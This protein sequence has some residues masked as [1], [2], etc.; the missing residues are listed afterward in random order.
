MYFRLP[1]WNTPA[2]WL[3]L[4]YV[5]FCLATHFALPQCIGDNDGD[6][7]GTEGYDNS[8]LAWTTSFFVGTVFAVLALSL[9]SR[10]SCCS[11][12]KSRRVIS[13][14]VTSGF[15]FG[16]FSLAFLTKGIIGR[17]FP[18]SGADDGH[19]QVGYFLLTFTSY[20]FW[21]ISSVFLLSLVRVAR[22]T[23]LFQEYYLGR[24]E[25]VIFFGLMI[26][27]FVLISLAC[28]WNALALWNVADFSVDDNNQDATATINNLPILLLTATTVAWN[29]LF[30]A[31]VISSVYVWTVLARQDNRNIMVEKVSHSVAAFVIVFLQLVNIVVVLLLTLY[32]VGDFKKVLDDKTAN[33][34]ASVVFNFCTLLTGWLLYNYILALF[35]AVSRNEEKLVDT[36][37]D[38]DGDE[39]AINSIPTD[40]DQ[41]RAVVVEMGESAESDGEDENQELNDRN[42]TKNETTFNRISDGWS[43]V[44]KRVVD[45]FT[46]IFSFAKQ[47]SESQSLSTVEDTTTLAAR[48]VGEVSET[49][50]EEL[51]P[52]DGTTVVEC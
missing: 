15:A 21:T 37:S 19:G 32:S 16:F 36:E 45:A 52:I 4:L 5:A 43:I 40:D 30:C 20:S 25:Y 10:C 13:R 48:S 8:V 23:I 44:A 49:P 7:C 42:L 47:E 27:C 51:T 3:T 38:M 31:F 11:C 34:V 46:D 2:L 22:D 24:H 41:G 29:M 39:D 17:Y 12:C 1:F 18:N 33:S 35:P 14:P 50:L 6:E 26:F 28:V 9:C